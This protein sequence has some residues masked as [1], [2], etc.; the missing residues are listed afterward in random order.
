M[1]TIALGMAYAQVEVKMN[2]I[3]NANL[4]R[5][6]TFFLI[7]SV[8]TP[9]ARAQSVVT[10]SGSMTFTNGISRTIEQQTINNSALVLWGDGEDIKL[11]NGAVFNNLADGVFRVTNNGGMIYDEDS[12]FKNYGLFE[13]TTGTGTTWMGKFTNYGTVS[14]QSGTLSFGYDYCQMAGSTILAGGDLNTW[15]NHISIF[16]GTLQGQGKIDVGNWNPGVYNNGTIIPTG[17]L[18]MT[19]ASYAQSGGGCLNIVMGGTNAGENYGQLLIS[20]GAKLDG[21]LTIT[22]TNGFHPSL[23]ESFQIFKCASRKGRFATVNCPDLGPGLALQ[24]NYTPTG[25]TI[26]VV[27]S[28]PNSSAKQSVAATGPKL[29]GLLSDRR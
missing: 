10:W 16:G 19:N 27:E 24:P 25:V 6:S 13:Q 26:T 3:L 17:L 21:T 15:P 7:L 22:L 5:K 8:L 9:S 12:S 11:A 14:I 1:A 2:T 29:G 23:G 18:F 28:S 20:L 4:L